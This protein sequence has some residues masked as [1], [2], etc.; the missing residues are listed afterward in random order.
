MNRA[1]ELLRNPEL[2][3]S[4]VSRSVGYTDPFLF[5]KMFKKVTGHSPRSSRKRGRTIKNNCPNRSYI[6]TLGQSWL[7]HNLCIAA[8]F[9]KGSYGCAKLRPVLLVIPFFRNGD[10]FMKM[11]RCSYKRR[12]IN[13]IISV[14]PLPVGQFVSPIAVYSDHPVVDNGRRCIQPFLLHG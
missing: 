8:R 9:L 13:V 12:N 2:T 6:L 5:S 3:I 1:I 10:D 7:Q 11:L 14:D 4:D